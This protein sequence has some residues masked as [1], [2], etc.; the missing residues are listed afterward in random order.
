MFT[1][2]LRGSCLHDCAS[3]LGNLLR[4]H[5]FTSK[6]ENLAAYHDSCV[7]PRWRGRSAMHARPSGGAD[8]ALVR[9]QA[10]RRRARASTAMAM[11]TPLRSDQSADTSARA[12]YQDRSGKIVSISARRRTAGDRKDRRSCVAGRALPSVATR[13]LGHSG[14]HQPAQWPR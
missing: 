8:A 14:R 6:Q 5:C 3:S 2:A 11:A 7:R 1:D 10:R 12:V 4:C 13:L 9:R